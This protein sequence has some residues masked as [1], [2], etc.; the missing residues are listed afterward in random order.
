MIPELFCG[1]IKYSLPYLGIAKYD[2]LA[3]EWVSLP[4]LAFGTLPNGHLISNFLG[5]VLLA[6]TFTSVG[7]RL[8]PVGATIGEEDLPWFSVLTMPPLATITLVVAQV[9][10]MNIAVVFSVLVQV[11]HGAGEVA[12]CAL[13]E[14]APE[15]TRT[16][17]VNV[18]NMWRTLP[19]KTEVLIKIR[20]C[21]K[22]CVGKLNHTCSQDSICC[23]R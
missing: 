16:V 15:F 17:Q 9:Y 19:S 8:S 3:A 1:S 21:T 13:R 23:C 2:L 5:D 7:V 14:F 10:R 11:A 22:P 12:A 18:F 20:P 4:L 6:T